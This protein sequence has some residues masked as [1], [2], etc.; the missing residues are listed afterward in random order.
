MGEGLLE[1]VDEDALFELRF[2]LCYGQHGGSALNLTWL[3]TLEVE[4]GELTRLA[5]KLQ[6]TREEEAAALRAAQRK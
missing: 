2:A 6:E 5:V 3:E 1:A 4:L